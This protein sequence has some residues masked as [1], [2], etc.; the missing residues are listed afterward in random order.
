MFSNGSRCLS[1]LAILATLL[2]AGFAL[3]QIPGD[4]VISEIMFNDANSGTPDTEWVEIHNTTAAAIDLSNWILSDATANPPANEGA[5]TIPSGTS[6]PANG[7]LVLCEWSL[8][9]LANEVVCTQSYGDFSLG[10][11]GDNIYLATSSGGTIIDGIAGTGS[12]NYYP[13]SG[14]TAGNSIERCSW[15]VAFNVP[16]NWAQATNVYSTTQIFRNCTPGAANTACG[17]DVTPPTLVSATATSAT[18]V[19]LLWSEAVGTASSQ[20]V[21]NYS[22]NNGIGN[23]LTANRDGTNNSL[24]HLTFNT[25]ANNTYTIT[26]SN[27]AD[28]AGNIQTTPQ[29]ANFTVNVTVAQGAVVI[30]EV[31]Y[32]DT[33]SVDGEWVELHNT[34]ASAINM[35]LW[36][37]TD[38]PSVPPATEGDLV[39][40]TGTIIPAGGYVVICKV[41]LAEIPA[42]IVCVDSGSFGLSNSPGDN[43]A[44]YTAAFAQLVDGSLSVLYPD[45][46]PSNLGYSIEKCN[47]NAQWS[48]LAADWHTSTNVFGTGRYARCTP[49]AANSACVADTD[50]PTI[51][52]ATALSTTLVQVLFSEPLDPTTAETA[53]NYSVSAGVGNPSTATLQTNTTTVNLAFAS[54]MAPNTYTLTVNNVADVALNAI[55]PNS[56]ANFTITAPNE[57]LKITE[58]MPNPA[59][60]NDNVGEWFEVYNAGATAVN[61]AGWTLSDNAGTDTIEAATINP[62]QYFVFCNNADSATN[63]GVPENYEFHYG[64]SSW[65]LALGNGT[66][67]DQIYLR[68]P[69]GVTVASVS[70]TSSF[71]WG[72][73][74]SAQLKDLNYSGAVDTMWCAG[75]QAWT[76]SSGDLGTPGA[77]TAC[78][79]VAPPDT[80]T[81]CQLRAQD[82]CGVATHL[83]ARVVVRGVITWVDPCSFDALVESGGCA[84]QLYGPEITANMIGNTRAPLT[85]DSVMIN[86]YVSQFHGVTEISPF[87]TINPTITY[88]GTG[89]VPAAVTVTAASI[90]NIVDN[91]TPET[92][93][94]RRVS[95]LNATFLETGNFTYGDTTYHALVGLDTVIF[96]L[97]SC[98]ATLLGTAIPTGAINITGAVGQYDSSAACLCGGYQLVYA[99]GTA[100]VPALCPDPV[101]LKVL[102]TTGPAN[103]VTLYWT[104]G[105]GNTCNTYRIWSSTDGS[106][107]FP[108]S[109]STVTT[110]TGVTS[111]V[112]NNPLSTRLFYHVTADN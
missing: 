46:S 68:N 14:I 106:A 91:C 42:A 88:L 2:L 70:Y 92:Y 19:D 39:I 95:V 29:T 4:V 44:L 20:L 57:N 71:P 107:V 6:I 38:A 112:D 34:T 78:Q 18:A 77:A 15:T 99:G 56:Q 82:A 63:G 103:S 74:V 43:L 37:L 87:T 105:L 62:G 110:V 104:P 93:E 72:S 23:P 13:S 11:S 3:A 61:L 81:V 24:V 41:A 76:G 1:F 52:S 86:G 28:V 5:M 32:D 21:T 55:L 26:A 67:G 45:L 89:T 101:Q 27:I 7:Y 66:T 69:V 8:P 16:S 60:V 33:G 100:F 53:T 108:T 65:G 96:Y 40:P 35:S 17:G 98:D 58:F 31:M 73:G 22:V 102:R 97:D 85:G 83:H 79:P 64:T 10:N 90:S 109:Y 75:Y 51:V 59:A 9:E 36:R 48:G 54:A 94:S 12:T 25:M 50:P 111:Y 80:L 30:T 49:G 84:V 47:V